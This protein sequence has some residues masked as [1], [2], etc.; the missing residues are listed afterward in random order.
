MVE[1]VLKVVVAVN[2]VATL[3]TMAFAALWLQAFGMA[4]YDTNQDAFHDALTPGQGEH[5]V[6]VARSILRAAVLPLL[7]TNGIWLAV[8]V[9]RWLAAIES[10]PNPPL[11]QTAASKVASRLES[12]EG[13]RC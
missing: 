5:I 7:A 11:Q 3:G 4:L 2:V 6:I 1:K 13:R 12:P 10:P 8:F 9:V